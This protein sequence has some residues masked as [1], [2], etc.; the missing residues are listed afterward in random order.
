MPHAWKNSAISR[1]SGAEPEMKYFT[2]PPKRYL[3]RLAPEL[4]RLGAFTRKKR[5]FNPPLGGWLRGDLAP[6]LATCAASLASLTG[7]QIDARRASFMVRAYANVPALAEQVLALVILDESL[8][9][10]AAEAAV[11]G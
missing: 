2:R 4:E 8:R 1:D 7:G 9:Q 5:G 3:A 10:L 11:G 6:R